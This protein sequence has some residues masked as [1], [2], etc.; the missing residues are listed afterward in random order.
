MKLELPVF[1][2]TYQA[3]FNENKNKYHKIYG[4]RVSFENPYYLIEQ[5]NELMD[6]WI[7]HHKYA[8]NSVWLNPELTPSSR[9]VHYHGFVDVKDFKKFNIFLKM[10]KSIGSFHIYVLQHPEAHLNYCCKEVGITEVCE[11]Q[12]KDYLHCIMRK[13]PTNDSNAPKSTGL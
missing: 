9:R 12:Y 7:K 11:Y 6:E 5:T 10:F 8:F 4:V 1:S 3:L 13:H 2:L